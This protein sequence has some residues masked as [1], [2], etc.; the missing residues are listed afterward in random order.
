MSMKTEEISVSEFKATCLRIIER[1][2]NT[3]MPVL[4][5]KNGKPAARLVPVE[6]SEFPE[7]KL[8]GALREELISCGD[9]VSPLDADDWEALR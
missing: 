9:L 8:Y 3:G 4:I 2:K 6:P 7:K 5:L 1:V